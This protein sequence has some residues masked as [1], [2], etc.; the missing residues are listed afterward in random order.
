MKPMTIEAAQQ[1]GTLTPDDVM[2]VYSGKPGCACGCRGKYSYN[3][4]HAAK[5]SERRGYAVDDEDINDREVKRILGLLQAN[6][7]AV[8]VIEADDALDGRTI[9]A[10]D[11]HENRTYTVYLA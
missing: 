9:F 5:G 6:V 7:E 4:R 2:C 8:K 10:F 11:K 1:L 3:S